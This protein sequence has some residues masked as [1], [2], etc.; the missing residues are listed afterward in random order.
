MK[1]TSSRLLVS[2]LT[3]LAFSTATLRAEEGGGGQYMIGA[4]SSA[5]DFSSTEPGFAIAT[6]L[7]GYSGDFSGGRAL[8]V[9]GI[10]RTGLAAE[11]LAWDI[12]MAY[13]FETKVLGANYSV[14]ACLPYLWLDV[15][16]DA[17]ITGPRGRTVT[18]RIKDDANGLTDMGVVPLALTWKTGNWQFT[19]QEAVFVPV[20]DYE[21][22]R[23][24]NLGKNI[25][26][27]DS[28]FGVSYLNPAKGLEFT[29]MSG[30][31]FSTENED[32]DYQNGAVMHTEA[33]IAQYLPLGKNT[34]LALGV[35]GFYY[36]QVSGDSGSGATL[37]DLKGR[38]AG[39]GPIVNLI[40][41]IGDKKLAIQA[42]WLPEIDTKN[43]LEGDWVWLTVGMV[44]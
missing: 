11:F 43:R 12:A 41:T 14:G 42:K 44:F 36:Q 3:M 40:Q 9:G 39:V 8:P 24:A 19:F 16:A 21:E 22:G 5:L 2:A 30:L 1:H 6:D 20:G 37:G 17:S 15:E 35:N 18:R 13:T 31:L 29:L 32:T 26:S 38:S 33:T 25:W 7:L 34:I 28:V 27:F 4:F 23:L 10:A